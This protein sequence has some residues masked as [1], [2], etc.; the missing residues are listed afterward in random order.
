MMTTT[1][2]PL[3]S[4]P[5]LSP[6]R[7]VIL[8]VGGLL[9]L[10][11]IT[12]TT[13]SIVDHMGHR[14]YQTTGELAASG[15]RHLLVRAPHGISITAN[16][17]PTDNNVHVRTSVEYGLARPDIVERSTADGVIL[18][19]DCH[20]W[21]AMSSCSVAYEVQV[22][23]DFSVDV[24]SST[25]TVSATGLDG[26]ARLTT[27]AGDIQVSQMGGDL[28]L[29]TSAGS[30][31]GTHLGRSPDSGDVENSDPDGPAV[32]ASTSAGNVTLAFTT[33]P[34]RVTAHASAGNVDVAVPRDDTLYQITT[35]HHAGDPHIDDSLR[36]ATSAR[37]IVVSSSAGDVT[38]RAAE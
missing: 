8:V 29:R 18:E 24:R 6:Q 31:V 36:S 21:M 37:A 7:K 1:L 23:R 32:E 35:E 13:L 28:T 11:V 3:A 33:P 30:V 17:D 12:V 34:E 16:T 26:I 10:I 22:P 2:T 9:S 15:T 4:A 14:S 20:G 19:A 38:V 25:G 27:S 5:P